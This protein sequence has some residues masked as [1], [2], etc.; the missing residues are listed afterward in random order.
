MLSALEVKAPSTPFG[1]HIRTLEIYSR[2]TQGSAFARLLAGRSGWMDAILAWKHQGGEIVT[3]KVNIESS[4]LTT[5]STGPQLQPGLR[6]L[7]FPLY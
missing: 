7:L 2:V 3:D 6:A 5:K 4:A 1:N